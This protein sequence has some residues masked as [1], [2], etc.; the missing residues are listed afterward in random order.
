MSTKVLDI[1][2][3]TVSF[4]GFKALNNLNFSMDEGELRVIIGPNGA[5]KT[6]F[7]DVITGKTKPTE[8]TAYFKGKDLRKFKE[9][10]IARLGIGRKFQTPRVYLNLTPRENLELSCNQNK[11]VFSTLLKKTPPAEKRT[12]GGLLETIGLDHKA[13]LPAALL[14]HGEKQWLE[15]GMLV[16][17]SPDLLLVDEPVAGLT[18][19]ETEQTGKLLMSLAESHSIVVIEHDMEFVRQI[20]RQVTVL[21]QGSVLCEGT[22]DQVQNDPRVVEV[23][24]GKETTLTPEQMLLLRIA[25]T[26]AW[27]DDNLAPVQQDLILDR[28]SRKFAH[29]SDEQASLKE[30]LKHLL[31]KEIPLEE[32]VPQLANESQKEE[33]L[34]ISYEVISSNQINSAEAAVYRKLLD[35]LGLPAETVSRLEAAALQDLAV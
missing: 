30:D 16:A 5:G 19:E 2:N 20:A 6:T 18:D 13:D 9:H 23:Y 24:L 34:M 17:Q 32:L 31:A 22:M 11:N 21:H 26:M 27:A 14:S 28:L 10:Q 25:A 7:L 15:I 12:V 3:V 4:D 1:Q 29:D 8:G 33:A 35:L